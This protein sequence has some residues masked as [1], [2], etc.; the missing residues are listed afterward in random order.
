LIYVG[1]ALGV[2]R[3]RLFELGEWAFRVLFITLG[4]LIMVAVD[5][6]LVLA[7]HIERAPALGL[8]L[9]MVG[10]LYLPLRDTLWRRLTRRRRLEDHELFGAVM[11]VAFA[12][13]LTAR[14]AHWR[15]LVERLYDPLEIASA[16]AAVAEPAIEQSGLVL[17]L[18]A[19]AGM[20]AL[21]VAYPWGGRGLFGPSQLQS[22][23]RL[24]DLLV[25]A[26]NSREAYERGV[27]EE[28]RRMAQDLHDDV[29]ARLLSGL[30]TADAPTRP[31]LHAA[32][33]DIRAIVSGLVGDTATLDRVLAEVR[34]EAARRLE[35]AGIA[36]D[37]PPYEAP[38]ADVLLDYRTRKALTS[39]VREAV[40]NVIR[41]SG[42][43]LVRA[44]V[45]RQPDR[46]IMT[47]AD[48][49]KGLPAGAAGPGGQ[50]LRN[51]RRRIEDICGVLTIASP[52]T[53]TQIRFEVP[54]TASASG[55]AP[56]VELPKGAGA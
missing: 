1:L 19:T 3:Y 38:E 16:S 28:R 55:L 6:A 22:A 32:L 46:L 51:L 18:P 36:L 49:G 4:T 50:G 24:V 8:S 12:P 41:H 44:T 52:G 27:T 5:A 30:H 45:V 53:G 14:A 23:R 25:Q 35:A 48:D 10:F 40:S 34:H 7:V 54:L 56:A 37:W 21:R 39:A 11:E 20:P 29:G 17:L 47:L 43:G 42:A 13:T 33:A 15:A 26:E 31:V 2:S 9:L